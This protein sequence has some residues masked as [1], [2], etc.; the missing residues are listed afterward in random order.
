MVVVC[1]MSHEPMSALKEVAPWNV[2]ETTRRRR[3]TTRRRNGIKRDTA[4]QD[5]P[6]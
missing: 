6:C 1:E 2:A 3:R 5:E 4:R